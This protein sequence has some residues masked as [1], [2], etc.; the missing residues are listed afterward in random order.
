MRTHEQELSFQDLR[1]LKETVISQ[2]TPRVSLCCPE[3]KERE[4]GGDGGGGIYSTAA[5]L[6]SRGTRL[7]DCR[8]IV[9]SLRAQ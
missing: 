2:F 6:V 4:G 8:E 7:V 1:L 3:E 5:I 9:I